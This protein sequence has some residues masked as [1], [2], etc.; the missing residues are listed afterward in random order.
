M[1]WLTRVFTSGT[2]KHAKLFSDNEKE[3]RRMSK[4]LHEPIHQR[5]KQEK[6]IDVPERK[7]ERA[8]QNGAI[9]V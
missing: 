6:H 5:G 2:N 8:K 1:F 7:V 9:Q 3:L 4:V